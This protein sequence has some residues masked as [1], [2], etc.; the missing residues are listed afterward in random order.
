MRAIIFAA[1]L[2][3]RL[4][5]FTLSH[6]KALI[7]VNG[8]TVLERTVNRLRE[9]GINDII[10]NVHHF[11][12]Q[13]I[14]FLDSHNSF[15]TSI[16]YSDESDLLLE[17]G[18]GIVKAAPMLED[19]EPF[20][21]C[22]ADVLT[23]FSLTEMIAD[24]IATGADVTLLTQDRTTSRYLYF[25]ADRRDL[26]GW[27]NMK[28]G[29]SLPGGFIPSGSMLRRAFDG[30]HIISQKALRLLCN[31]SADTPFG[32]TPWY[33]ANCENLDIR[34]YTPA[35]P[36]QWFDIGSP[37]TLDKARREFIER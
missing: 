20:V 27:M 24:H 12:E 11:P 35:K 9:A 37:E 23:D 10:V 3:T 2:G 13:I 16:R 25:D 30:Y 26:K 34:A 33:V 19:D 8:K 28:T 17:T 5:P 29:D 32:I 18:G 31:E 15:G 21:A 14:D 1:G 6:P 4:K 7:E 36:F 22:N